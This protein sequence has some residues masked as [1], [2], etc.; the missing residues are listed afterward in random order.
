VDAAAIPAVAKADLRDELSAFGRL[1]VEH[2]K[3]SAAA[4]KERSITAAR[5]AADLV[6]R[7]PLCWTVSL[8]FVL[9]EDATSWRI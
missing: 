1:I 8:P 2:A 5:D 9:L 3:K 6:R 4:N 7:A